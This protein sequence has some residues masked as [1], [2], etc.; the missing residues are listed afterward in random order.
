MH[1]LDELLAKAFEYQSQDI[2]LPSPCYTGATITVLFRQNRKLRETFELKFEAWRQLCS[3]LQFHSGYA[4]ESSD[5]FQDRLLEYKNHF[6]RLA[7]TP[8]RSPYITIRLAEKNHF[9]FIYPKELQEYL[10]SW[11][12]SGGVLMLAGPIHSGKT[13]LYYECLDR[14]YQ[15]GATLSSWED[16]IEKNIPHLNQQTL[17]PERWSELALAALR[18]DWDIVGIGEVR[19][20]THLEQL[21]FL[22]LS[23]VK[24]LTPIH[25]SSVIALRT[26]MRSLSPILQEQLKEVSCGVIFRSHKGSL[27]WNAL[28]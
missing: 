10:D 1:Y 18:F 7:F 15:S 27:E 6:L 16:P 5:C 3:Y 14:A 28:F 8:G 17:A 26:K 20:L 21:V 9:P 22:S 2:H 11:Q 4:Y 23:S 24:T 19:C 13:T 25:A 12:K